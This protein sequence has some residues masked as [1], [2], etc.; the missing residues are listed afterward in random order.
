MAARLF[1]DVLPPAL[2]FGAAAVLWV[3]LFAVRAAS[4]G[5]RFDFV[6]WE[7][8]AL[9]GAALYRLGAPLRTDPAADAAL[10]GYFALSDRSAPASAALESAAEAAIAGRIDAVLRAQGIGW[11]VP[12]P[13]TLFP[14]VNLELA[15]APRALVVSPRARIA[16]VRTE[17]L[18]PDF[19]FAAGETLERRIEADRTLSALVVGTGGIATYPAIVA[20]SEDYA[21][22]VTAAAHEWVHHY[23]ALY[24]LG[25]AYFSGNAETINETVADVVGEE[26]A[27]LVIEHWGTPL[28]PPAARRPVID[29]TAVLRDLRIEV[30]ALLAA[31]RIEDAER[32]MQTVRVQL[33]SMGVGIRRIN[34][35]YFAWYGTYAARPD[36][37]DPLGGQ[38]RA[39]RARAGSLARFLEQIRALSTREEVARLAGGS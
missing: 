14:P 38:V 30:D 21:G 5:D 4:G 17:A 36:S 7:V 28:A 24:P 18:R 15:A 25:R 29:A 26:V 22:T 34:Q 32:R 27:R 35:A 11:P 9:P 20:S 8:Q 2:I 39:A 23:L 33:D 19:T 10:A 3:A 12:A 31:G 16:R 37:I 1:R 6:R 13:G